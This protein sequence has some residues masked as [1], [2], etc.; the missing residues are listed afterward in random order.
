M[1]KKS[2]RRT[3]RGARSQRNFDSRKTRAIAKAKIQKTFSDETQEL[4]QRREKQG[5]TGC[6]KTERGCFFVCFCLAPSYMHFHV[7]SVV[8]GFLWF[9]LV[10]GLFVAAYLLEV[11][12]LKTGRLTKE[13]ETNVGCGFTFIIWAILFGMF[14]LEYALYDTDNWGIGFFEIGSFV[15]LIMGIG[16]ILF[17]IFKRGK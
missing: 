16:I 10:G 12:L 5:R 2:I 7:G 15:F 6:Q 8:A 9:F 17:N 1:L 4:Q 3:Y 11:H 13:N 14:S